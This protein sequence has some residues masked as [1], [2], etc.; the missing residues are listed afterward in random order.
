[1]RTRSVLVPALGTVLVATMVSVASSAPGPLTL[2]ERLVGRQPGETVLVPENKFVDPAGDT[3]EQ[4]GQV[5]DLEVHPGGRTAV[6]LTASGD[7]L[8]TVVDLET[9]EVL[10][11]YTPPG[12]VGDGRIG[13]GGLLYSADGDTLWAAQ[14]E[15]LLRFDVASDGT[16]SNPVEVAMPRGRPGGAPTSPSGE[17]ALPLPSDLTWAPDGRTMLVPLSGWDSLVALRARDGAVLWHTPVGRAPRDVVVVGG[18]AYVSNEAGRRPREGDFTNYSYNS[19]VVVEQQNGRASTGSVAKVSLAEHRVVGAYQ[20]GLDP[21]ALLAVGTDVLV[22]NSSD[23]TVSVIDTAAGEVARTFNVNPLPGQP[24]GSSPNALAMIDDEHLAVSLGRNNALAIYRF[25]GAGSTPSFQGLVPTA[26]YPGKVVL[27]EALGKLV[28]GNLKGVGALGRISTILQGPGTEPAT[29]KQVYRD[30]GVVQVLDVPDPDQLEA[31]TARVFAL[32]QWVGLQARNPVGDGTASPVPVPRRIGDPSP[33]KHVFLIVKENRTYDQVL[34]DDPRGNGAERLTQF[35]PRFTPNQHALARRFPLIDNLYSDGTNSATG[36]TWLDAGFVNDYLERSYANYVRNYG[37]PD[38][39]VYPRSGFLWDNAL[40]HG[41][42][43]RV[44]GEYAPYFTAPDGT[45]AGGSWTTWYRDAQILAGEREGELHVPVGYYQ[46]KSDVPSLDRILARRYPNYQTQI[47]D[48]YRAEL[49]LDDLARYEREGGL[50]ALNMLW[51]MADHTEGTSPGYPTPGAMVADNDL[52]TGRIVDAISHSRF[53]RSSAIFIV[54]DDSQNGVDHV[55]GHR[56]I[57]FVASPYARRGAV[58]STYYTQVNLT[59]TIEQILG[60]PPMNQVDLAA[61]P[62]WDVFTDTPDFRPFEYR[63]ARISLNTM[64]ETLA[65]ADSRIERRWLR[66]SL[67]QDYDRVDQL[68]FEPFNRLIWYSSYNFDRAYP[69]DPRV[70]T[71][72]EVLRRFP[73]AP[74][75]GDPDGLLPETRSLSPHGLRLVQGGDASR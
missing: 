26:W 6:D 72:A 65:E 5:I 62:M 35:G 70:L 39:M 46:T 51:V 71:P 8:F 58:D 7:G 33:I 37:Q 9:L 47:P 15:N 69:G 2:G 56:T 68:A 18:H 13:V 54:E 64:N 4:T 49:F 42:T 44:W 48:Q 14:T 63:E 66:W 34:G 11:Q 52:A 31:S 75:S 12:G 3:I 1:M 17:K 24:Y 38:A 29:G 21:S 10:Q 27:D 20:V 55:D 30:R 73:Q 19:P 32:N 61:E 67:R 74:P 22:T 50:P 28:V 16:L 23:D 59:R 25:A 60:L 57:T 41:L 53:W 45:E 43:A 36:H 40:S